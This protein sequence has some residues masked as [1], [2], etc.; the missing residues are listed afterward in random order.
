MSLPLLE[1][2]TGMTS[3]A[4]D[5]VPKPPN[6]MAF[7][8]VPNGKNM[9]D[10]TPKTPGA[11]FEL[12]PILEPLSAVKNKLLVV[13]GLTADGARAYA[14]GGGD[15]ARA[16]SAFLTGARPLKTD[17]V[18]IRNGVSVDQV[19][20]ARVGDQTRLASL[21]IGTEAGAM[22]GNCDSGYSCVYSSTMS[23]RSATQPLPKEV[24]PKIV[25]DRLF[26]Q[27][28]DPSKAKRD[29]KRKSILDFVRE[30]S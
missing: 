16:L 7:L 25:F 5:S 17:G 1:G 3:W 15:H 29:A 24:N 13:S 18:N 4:Q 8:Y 12:T 10:W 30:D 28:N 9:A 26:G 20:A 14:D 21:E 6:R 22:A 2:M 11:D 19:A 23:W 27:S